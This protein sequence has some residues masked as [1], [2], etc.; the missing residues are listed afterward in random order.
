MTSLHGLFVPLITPF[1]SGGAL[2]SD[3]LERHAHT[4]LDAGATGLVALGTTA[5]TSALTGAERA[6]VLD[7]CVRVCADRDAPLIVGAGGNATAESVDVIAALP[8]GVAAVLAVVP[9]YVRPTEEGVIAHFTRVAAAS[10]VPVLVYDVPY[11][12]ARTLGGETLVRLADIPNIAGFKHAVGGVTA[13][14]VHLVAEAGSR[15]TILSGDDRFASAQL[16]LGAHGA[17]LAAANVAPAACADLVAS[18]L[19]G[20]VHRG[21]ALGNRLDALSAALFA[22]PNPTVI[23][24]VL[25]ARGEIP[26]PGVR[27]PL[28]AATAEATETALQAYRLAVSAVT[29]AC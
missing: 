7:I 23:K 18:W 19:A 4:V 20:D 9:Y 11:R 26:D 1:T 17:I 5:E 12:T 16:A 8:P 14:T 15:T 2:A 10:P 6:R 25:A 27:L 24:S 28:L 29:V 22:E 21:R 13:A 3:A